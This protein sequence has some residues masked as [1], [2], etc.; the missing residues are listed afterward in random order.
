MKKPPGLAKHVVTIDWLIESCNRH[1][2][3]D[4]AAYIVIGDGT[5][6]RQ[7]SF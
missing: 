1:E 3:L 7:K 4:E 5:R 2:D 6:Q